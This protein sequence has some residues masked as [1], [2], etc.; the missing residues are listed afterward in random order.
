VL[1]VEA[2]N[3]Q[4]LTFSRL[5]NYTF[6]S[7]QHSLVQGVIEVYSYNYNATTIQGDCILQRSFL[8]EPPSFGTSA[9]S[10]LSSVWA[11]VL[12]VLF[13]LLSQ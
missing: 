11:V 1:S 3:T 5:G 10:T 6:Y 7:E 12:N 2:G 8:L 9:A 4:Q 13:W